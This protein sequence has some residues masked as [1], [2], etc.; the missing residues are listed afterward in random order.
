MGI[1]NEFYFRR[2]FFCLKKQVK[3]NCTSKKDVATEKIKN[4]DSI[5]SIQ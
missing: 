5:R 3:G 4:S 2:D 1:A